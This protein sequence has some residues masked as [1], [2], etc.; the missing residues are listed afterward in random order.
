MA[1]TTQSNSGKIARPVRL[2]LTV[3]AGLIVLMVLVGGATRLTGSGLSITEWKPVMGA[4]PPLS[5][6]AWQDAFDKY[7][8]IPEYT[9]VNEGMSLAEFKIIFWWEWAH[10]FLGRIIG[11]VFLLPFLWFLARGH[12]PP[13]LRWPLAGLFVLGA[14]QGALGWYMVKSGLAG[15]IDVSQY[16]LAAHL[17]LA[18]LIYTSIVWIVLREGEGNRPAAAGSAG[19]RASSLGIVAVVFLQIVAGAFVAGMHAGRSHN[20]WPLMD[21]KFIPDGLFVMSPALSNFF[22][23]ALTVQFNHR[24]LAYGIVAW[25]LIHAYVATRHGP[26]K[27]SAFWLSV[28]IMGQVALGIWTLL[29]VVPLPLGLAH[30]AGALV[31]LTVA[32]IH[33]AALRRGRF[34]PD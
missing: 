20:T 21:E 22:E 13:R 12:I 27:Q 18:V 19:L 28:T 14:L 17:G 5:D 4:V 34:P 30:Q 2:W 29:T 7:K 15:R 9:E 3:V 16:R 32:L 26:A 6:A 25:I 31:V 8:L 24:M 23:N 33:A 10:R 1:I 11:V